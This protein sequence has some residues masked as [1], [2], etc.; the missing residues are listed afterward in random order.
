[1]STND[2]PPLLHADEVPIDGPLV[3]SLIED[4]FPHWSHLPLQRVT[5]TGTDNAIFRLGPNM[6]VR[7]PRIERAVQQV[8]KE[9]N[10]LPLLGPQLPMAVPTP[11]AKGH[12][13][14]GYPFPWLVYRWLDGEDLQHRPVPDSKRFGRDLAA[15]V[16]A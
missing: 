6:G 15:F 12:P 9:F 13:G 14:R 10:W 16:T 11:V 1:M 4:Q 2:S 7:L 5:S 8:D 3:Q